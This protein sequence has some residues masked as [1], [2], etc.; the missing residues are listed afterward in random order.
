MKSEFEID[1]SGFFGE[2]GVYFHGDLVTGILHLENL[3]HVNVTG[4]VLS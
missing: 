4:K 1:F 3:Q 2:K